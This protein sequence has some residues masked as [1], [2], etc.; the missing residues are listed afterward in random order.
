MYSLS[1]VSNF[2][3]RLNQALSWLPLLILAVLEACCT[4]GLAFAG[5]FALNEQSV[6][7]LGNA[8][9]GSA[10]ALEDASTIFFN[11]AGL[12]RLPGN[13]VVGAGYA[14]F[15]G[16]RFQNQG[17]IVRTGAPLLGGNGGNAG[18]DIV[19]PN[20]YTALS[21]SN[22]LKIGLGINA[23][24]G[25]ATKYDSDWVGRYQAIESKLTTI[26]INPT[27]ALKLTNNFSVGAGVDV[28][29]ASALLTNAI[30][31]GT[32]GRSSGLPSQPQKA[33]GFV[34]ITGNDWSVGYNLGLMYE[35]TKTTRVGVAY[36]SAITQNLR[37]NAE[38]TV[39][40]SAK[41]LTAKEQFTNTGALAVLK[42]PDSLSIAASQQLSPNLALVGDVTWTHW[43]RFQEL[44]VKFDNQQPDKVQPEHWQD[45]Y[46]LGL[47][48]NYTVNRTLTVRTGVTYDP[49]SV[50]D[51][52][53]TARIPGGDRT[54]L[55]VGAS[56]RPSRMLSLDV[57][58]THVFSGDNSINQSSVTDGTLKGKFNSHVDVVGVQLNYKF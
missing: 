28:Q 20:L 49:S 22:R 21:L 3:L 54:L 10:A 57:G 14:I 35:P 12:T 1:L 58:Y 6:T 32:I 44:R 53:T 23:P 24:F 43:S 2:R 33:D 17:S 25:L 40:N 11:P 8:F 47:G 34:K 4:A 36:R 41:L 51:K 46:R 31:F 45:T 48:A 5:G 56:Y 55:G 16:V 38:F 37:G 26:N 13:S 30:D 9:A 42:L 39:P 15:P 7:G 50:R 19:I 29:Y 18:V 27:V 52:F